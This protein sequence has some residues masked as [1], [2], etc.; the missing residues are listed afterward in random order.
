MQATTVMDILASLRKP[1]YV[2]RPLQIVRRLSRA[3]GKVPEAADVR[4]PWGLDLRVNPAETIGSCVW[5]V[6]IYDLCV[7]ESLWRLLEPGETALDIG[8]NIGHMTGLMA[9]RLGR[10]GKVMAFEP[11]PEIFKELQGNVSRWQQ[12]CTLPVVELVRAGVSSKS[13]Q[14]VLHVPLEFNTNHGLASL[15]QPGMGD[16][17]DCEVPLVTLDDLPGIAKIGAMKLDVEGHELDVL[18][19]AQQMITKKA[20]RDII[21][22]EHAATP[23][24]VTDYLEA[25]GYAVFHLDVTTLRPQIVPIRMNR[26]EGRRDAPNLLATLDPKRAESLLSKIGWQVLRNRPATIAA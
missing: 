17:L 5:R 14:G 1:E 9:R 3:F 12:C 4:L 15:S 6:G 7:S 20:I 2:F 16:F 10:H 13:G 19:G 21:F 11:H 25:Y 24:P 8:A 22:E 26:K 23:T 18:K